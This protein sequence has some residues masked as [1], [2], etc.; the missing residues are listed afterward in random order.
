MRLVRV[1]LLEL[2]P[3]EMVVKGTYISGIKEMTHHFLKMMMVVLMI[4]V[5]INKGNYP[6]GYKRRLKKKQIGITMEIEIGF[7]V[8]RVLL[9]KMEYIRTISPMGP[10]Y[11]GC[12][13]HYSTQLE[14]KRRSIVR[15]VIS[16]SRY[17]TIFNQFQFYL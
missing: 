4:K 17:I 9:K 10:K 2:M 13:S 5:I 7:T 8:R 12:R 3:L 1:G 16:L 11:K 15:G 14:V 6:N